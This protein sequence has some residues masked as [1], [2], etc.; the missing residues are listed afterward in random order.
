MYCQRE[1]SVVDSTIGDY[2]YWQGQYTNKDIAI[3]FLIHV[4]AGSRLNHG[5]NHETTKLVGS[6]DYD[7][8]LVVARATL[9]S[10]DTGS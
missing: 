4:L 6:K 9:C 10:L 1:K 8:R 3:P 5:R 7:L 2:C